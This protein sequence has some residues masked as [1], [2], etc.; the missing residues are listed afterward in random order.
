MSKFIRTTITLPE[1]LYEQ[2]R[3]TAFHRRTNLSHLVR[4]GVRHIVKT[5]KVKKGEG[6]MSLAGKYKV[7]KPINFTR[8]KFYGDLIRREMSIGY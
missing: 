2:L 4:E 6:I 5:A 3:A 1:N 8:K 7:K